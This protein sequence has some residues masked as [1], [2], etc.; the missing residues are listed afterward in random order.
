MSKPFA[1]LYAGKCADCAEWFKP[2]T[3]IRYDDLGQVVH[4]ECE[5]NTEL[6][7][8]PPMPPCASGAGSPSHGMTNCPACKQAATRKQHCKARTC[9]WWT[10]GRCGAACD[11]TGR[12][13]QPHEYAGS[14][15]AA[16]AWARRFGVDVT[17]VEVGK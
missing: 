8:S 14:L 7:H 15:A 13:N 3:A 1:A 2:G 10:C 4:A 9:S 6:I 5:G 11:K 12:W 17:F 16:T